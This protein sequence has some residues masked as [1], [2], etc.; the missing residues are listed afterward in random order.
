MGRRTV[1]TYSSIQEHQAGIGGAAGVNVGGCGNVD[2]C[3]VCACGSAKKRIKQS[4]YTQIVRKLIGSQTTHPLT[5]SN[6]KGEN[7]HR[8]LI[9]KCSSTVIHRTQEYTHSLL[10]A[11]SPRFPGYTCIVGVCVSVCVAL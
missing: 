4:N 1:H 10:P 8:H 2:P 3:F 7:L 11:A 9:Y 6:R 5:R